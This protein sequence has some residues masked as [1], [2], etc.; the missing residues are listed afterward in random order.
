[1]ISLSS[2]APKAQAGREAGPAPAAGW[3]RKDQ[4]CW[5]TED[6]RQPNPWKCNLNSC[7]MQHYKSPRFGKKN[8]RMRSPE[9]AQTWLHQG[10]AAGES[11]CDPTVRALWRM[12]LEPKDVPQ[13]V[14]GGIKAG[15]IPA[16]GIWQEGCT[17]SLIIK[18][19][20][21]FKG[22]RHLTVGWEGETGLGEPAGEKH[23]EPGANSSEISISSTT[24]GSRSQMDGK[25]CRS[26]ADFS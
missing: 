6:P 9:C 12:E 8:E 21:K 14:Q 4:E 19:L 7:S 3:H 22:K 10:G 25:I 18:V 11:S 13:L 1:M 24:K 15:S 26:Q 16:P 5:K 20:M 17:K 23:R 2:G